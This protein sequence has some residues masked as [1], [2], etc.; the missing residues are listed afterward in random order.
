MKVSS[1]VL[2]SVYCINFSSQETNSQIIFPFIL[3]GK[4]SHETKANEGRDTQM[5]KRVSESARVT[6]TCLANTLGPFIHG[7]IR[8]VSHKTRLK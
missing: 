2:P 7:K 4:K 8:R 1:K 3:K 6:T 5:A